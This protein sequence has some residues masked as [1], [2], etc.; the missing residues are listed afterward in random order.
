MGKK[1]K[2]SKAA[3]IDWR[4]IWLQAAVDFLVGFLLLLVDK[5][6]S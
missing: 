4:Q 2:K 6:I 3:K 5:F 1:R